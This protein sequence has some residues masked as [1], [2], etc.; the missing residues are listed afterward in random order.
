M[1]RKK[2]LGTTI[3]NFSPIIP[4]QR[5]WGEACPDR[6][7]DLG[8]ISLGFVASGEPFSIPFRA[9]AQ[10]R[11]KT[12]SQGFGYF[13]SGVLD[14]F[15]KVISHFQGLTKIKVDNEGKGVSLGPGCWSVREN[16]GGL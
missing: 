16:F 9:L 11:Y 5:S 8:A 3:R 12:N 7:E 1:R 14:R 2:A 15:I 6:L 4:Q 13:F 10:E